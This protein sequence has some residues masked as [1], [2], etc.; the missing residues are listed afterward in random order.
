MSIIQ[1]IGP[2]FKAAPSRH[3]NR[4]HK[5]RT[6]NSSKHLANGRL[7]RCCITT[8]PAPSDPH[9]LKQ[10]TFERGM[11]MRSSDR[12]AIPMSRVAHNAI[13]HE[14]SLNEI[15]WFAER[16]IDCLQFARDLWAARDDFAK[17]NLVW[18]RH[19]A[20]VIYWEDIK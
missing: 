14:A 5:P 12:W 19:V 20:C 15:R 9:H 7:L 16:G 18:G 8:A 17:M 6:G 1:Q 2:R 13:E 3:R 10:D 11:A 4:Q